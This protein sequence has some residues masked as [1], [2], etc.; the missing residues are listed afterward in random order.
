MTS[1][2]IVIL[3]MSLTGT[4][5][6]F[7]LSIC[8]VAVKNK[9]SATWYYLM[10]ILA[11]FFLFVPIGIAGSGIYAGISGSA[12]GWLPNIAAVL[13]GVFTPGLSFIPYVWLIGAVSFIIWHVAQLMVFKRRILRTSLEIQDDVRLSTLRDC[14]TQIGIRRNFRFFSSDAVKTPMLIGLFKVFLILPEVEMTEDEVSVI[15]KHELIHLKRHDL[16]AK[17]LALLANAIHWFNPVTYRLTK[18][19]HTF[20]ELSCDEQVVSDMSMEERRFYGETILNVICRVANQ[21]PGVYATLAETKRGIEKRL[22]NI[23]NV[24]KASKRIAFLAV[25]VAVALFVVCSAMAS[26]VFF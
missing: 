1:V 18:N 16:W 9:F 8:R 2:F 20:C 5:H 22:T 11:M 21:H 3:L 24:K 4:V 10:Y 12:L 25:T 26:I 23:M 17:S 19:I 15:L 7:V 13:G 6:L 14:L